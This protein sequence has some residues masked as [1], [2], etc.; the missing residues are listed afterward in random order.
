MSQF[1][2]GWYVIYTR[3]NREKQVEL[4]LNNQEILS[5]LPLKKEN[6][7]WSD[8]KK[9]LEVPLFP[10]Y[11]FAYLK[12]LKDYVTAMQVDGIVFFLKTDRKLAIINESV[13]TALRLLVEYG[14]EFEITSYKEG[15]QLTI[16]CGLLNGKECSFVEWNGCKRALVQVDILQR[17]VLA[18]LPEE[19]LEASP[20]N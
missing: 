10:S 7:K 15:Q 8:R 20:I 17:T 16:R 9:L 3:P 13:I 1:H 6:R 2:P 18:T 12:N 14:Q 11:I 4:R 5:F 19:F